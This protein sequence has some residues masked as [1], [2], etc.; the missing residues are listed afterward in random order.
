MS[1]PTPL[2]YRER[3]AGPF[4]AGFDPP[5]LGAERGRIAGTRLVA[6]LVVTIDDFAAFVRTPEHRARLGGTIAFLPL[7]AGAALTDAT[8]ELAVADSE[9]GM[10]RVCYDGRFRG[11]DG[12]PYRWSATKFIRPGRATL[13]ERATAYAR[14]T[15]V[16]STDDG[17]GAPACVVASGVIVADLASML[18]SIASVRAAGLSWREA[19]SRLRAFWRD[20]LSTPAPILATS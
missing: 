17:A 13:R 2:S 7:T 11:D 1:T 19:V 4:A 5:R 8:V 9:V 14:L 15:T 10:K 6:D 20:E 3:L 18:A 16:P 12:T